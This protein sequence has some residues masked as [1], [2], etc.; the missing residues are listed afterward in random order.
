MTLNKNLTI[1]TVT[2]A[3]ILTSSPARSGSDI[4]YTRYYSKMYD[5]CM[6][7]SDGM[8]TESNC[9]ENELN[10]QEG[11]LNQAYIMVMRKLPEAEKDALRAYQ[12]QWV[13]NRDADCFRKAGPA[14]NASV[15]WAWG[16]QIDETV[17]RRLQLEKY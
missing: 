5:K 3:I 10:F 14:N 12:R 8:E 4:D 2:A 15:R 9:V 11:R 13:A 16:C 7:R 1:T 17:K 6:E